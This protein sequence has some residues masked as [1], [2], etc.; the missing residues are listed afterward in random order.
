MLNVVK[1]LTWYKGSV[2]P[3]ASLWS[4]LLRATW[5]N[6]LHKG[7]IYKIA[8]IEDKNII[9]ID[10]RSGGS[11]AIVTLVADVLGETRTSFSSFCLKDQIPQWLY[12][13]HASARPRCCPQCIRLGYHTW[14]MSIRLVVECPIH[15]VELRSHC[16]RCGGDLKMGLMGLAVRSLGCRCGPKWGAIPYSM[17][18]PTLAQEGINAWSEVAQWVH[19]AE[20]MHVNIE[21]SRPDSIEQLALTEKW[22]S[23]LGIPY[24]ACFEKSEYFWR[25]AKSSIAH[26]TPYTASTSINAKNAVGKYYSEI[27]TNPQL[28]VYRAMS[29]HL[30]RQAKENLDQKVV[31][32]CQ[33]KDPFS[34]SRDFY[35]KKPVRDAFLEMLWTRRL[36]NHAYLWRWPRREVHDDHKNY[37]SVFENFFEK[38]KKFAYTKSVS[39]RY[40]TWLQ[41]HYSALVCLI[42]WGEAIRQV[43]KS[44]DENWAD[45]T[46]KDVDWKEG[47]VAWYSIEKYEKLLFVG[48]AKNMINA[49]F[50]FD[51]KLRPVAS[52]LNFKTLY[53]NNYAV[54]INEKEETYFSSVK[55]VRG[56]SGFLK[57]TVFESFFYYGKYKIKCILFDRV[58]NFVATT[59]DGILQSW[60]CDKESALEAIRDAALVFCR[61]YGGVAPSGVRYSIGFESN[62]VYTLNLLTEGNRFRFTN[63]F[64]N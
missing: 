55:A 7:D 41:Y 50:S 59:P 58:F 53:R 45:W 17:R 33:A 48:Y 5:L 2:L 44:M 43:E 60:G 51:I 34:L 36:E 13:D 8:Q 62:N 18:Q 28:S 14:L 40:D 31:E 25:S 4:T 1:P 35:D 57:E 32:A 15:H 52:G 46:T 19:H 42:A 16:E 24:P 11:A 9:D 22:C 63:R 39:Y 56:L 23:D 3:Y 37:V 38:P 27:E 61:N 10:A 54:E 21:A 12:L 29:R 20:K 49:S 30:R 47:R 6:D 26:W 64:V